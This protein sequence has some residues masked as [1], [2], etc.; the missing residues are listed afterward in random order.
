MHNLDA[1]PV[2]L[3]R[4]ET[5]GLEDSLKAVAILDIAH[6]ALGLVDGCLLGEVASVGEV[7]PN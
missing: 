4:R 7:F 5:L 6:V 1:F 3:V 2:L